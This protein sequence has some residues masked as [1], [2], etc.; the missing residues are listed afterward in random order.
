M[1]VKISIIL[2]ISLFLL[3]FGG[4][5]KNKVEEKPHAKDTSVAVNQDIDRNKK[6]VEP[7]FSIPKER[8]IITA[9]AVI[10]TSKGKIQIGLYGRD[11][12][13]TVKN[14]IGLAKKGYYNGVLFHRIAKKF[15]IQ[16]GD[17]LTKSY[18][19]K[20]DWGTGG[21]SIYGV[22]FEDELN[23]ETAS[24]K[25]G[26]VK[27]AIAMANRGPNTNTSQFFICLEEAENL[28]HRWTIFGRVTDGINV[29][30][31]ISNVEVL[32]SPRGTKDGLP[33][34]PV[35]VFSIRILN[36]KK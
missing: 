32:P 24:S 11:A 5:K 34:D 31:N 9:K 33:K 1:R 7:K 22:E 10:Y 6:V 23:P 27:G 2:T 25:I 21:E 15:L 36:N 16:T 28:E 4:C 3:T 29:V 12:P 30:E 14:F 8:A 18:S 19:K 26:Y 35:K 13:R 20:A 17:P